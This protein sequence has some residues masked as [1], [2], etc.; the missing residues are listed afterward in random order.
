MTRFGY[1]R[2]SATSQSLNDQIDQLTKAGCTMVRSEKQSGKTFEGREELKTLL[3][4][5]RERDEVV[6]TRIDR[7]AR[8]VRDLCNIVADLSAKGVNLIALHQSIDTGSPAGMAFLQMLGVF[9][10]FERALILDRQK[11]GIA[12]ARA[13]GLPLGGRKAVISREDVARLKAENVGAAEIARRLKI[14]P[15]SVYRILREIETK[16]KSPCQPS[17]TP[18]SSPP[19]ES[20]LSSSV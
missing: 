17:D 19:S 11:A 18:S 15:A 13:A 5:V 2:V 4:F 10:E 9:A 20:P 1:A 14:G 12:A 8:S 3:A 7:L 16:G 6:V